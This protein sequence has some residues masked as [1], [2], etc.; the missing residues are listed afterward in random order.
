MDCAIRIGNLS[1]VY[2]LYDR[3]LD[4]LKESLR[5][6]SRKYHRDFYALRDVSFDVRRGETVGIIGRNGSGK[7]TLLKVI[8]GVLTSTAG[9]VRVDG[10]VSA[11][12]E[13]GAGFNPE[14]TGLENIYLQGTLMGYPEEEMRRREPDILKFAGIGDFIHQPVKVY[15]SGMF[16]RLAF[17]VAINVDPEI[18]IVDEALAVGDMA[19]Q[20]K[21]M[22]AFKRLQQKGVTVLFV[23]HDT[24]AVK[25]L[26]ERAVWL[27][28]GAIRKVGPAGEIAEEYMRALREEMNAANGADSAETGSEPPAAALPATVWHW[29]R[30]DDIDSF[31]Q[32]VEQF[33]YGGG[34][35]RIRF[36][37]LLDGDG[38]PVAEADF[39]QEVRLR[40]YL[41]SGVT[42][43]VSV[44][45]YLLDDK[46][47]YILGSGVRLAGSG[48]IPAEAGRKYRVTYTT[49]L[50][51]HEGHYSVHLQVTA[52]IVPD[53]TAE[54]LD[55]VDDAAVL[56]V[57]RRSGAQ[58][59]AKVYVPNGLAVEALPPEAAT[60]C[61]VCGSTGIR[62]LPLPGLY[63]EMA[64]KT[65]YRY[66]G[67]GEMTAVDTYSCPVCGASDRERL[68]A[69]WLR[70]ILRE[71]GRDRP[72]G[73][74][75]LL[76]FAPE[77][78]LSEWL[79]A[80]NG[81]D[82]ET[83]D[84]CRSDVT[85]RV[86]ITR[87]PFGDAEYDGFIC[88]HV[89]EHVADDRAALRELHR[90][91]KPGGFGILVAPVTVGLAETLEDPA[92]VTEEDRWRLF[93]QQDHVRLYC[94]DGYVARLREGGFRVRELDAAYFGREVF[95]S[96][97]LKPTSILYVVERAAEGD[98]RHAGQQ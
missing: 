56:K 57:R 54:F 16:V 22:T 98:G 68:F 48:L 33:R 14:Y 1:K 42:Q 73:R 69:L 87:L 30:Q 9:S 64:A 3:P 59:W 79:R 35:V 7:S 32:R 8:T 38:Q 89:L 86:D 71:A 18:L 74:P 20:A 29:P 40:I 52:P 23:S 12:L 5:P 53:E 6:G 93:G 26:C 11:L 63:A 92:A 15:S 34:G 2:K 31:T 90:I 81:F 39:D 83:A 46:K 37:E 66:F 67:Q 45:Y 21:C 58:V 25:S 88:S 76:H 47:N 13:L 96:M 24:A 36:L 19:F 41:E 61:P 4:R 17:S 62:F 43:P 50:P 28:D 51:L 84:L 94:H 82:Y 70:D 60:Y 80:M 65:G 27:E 44:N 75:R 85:H 10:R 49:R 77:A 95:Q 97:G 72:E 91:L 55:V 78:A